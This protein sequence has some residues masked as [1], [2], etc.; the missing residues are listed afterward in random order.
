MPCAR[1]CKWGNSLGVRIPRDIARSLG[2]QAGDMLEIFPEKEGIS[3]RKGSGGKA[4][5]LEDIIEC[6]TCSETHPEVSWGDP[7][8]EETW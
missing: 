1:V 4:Y 8:G 6:F 7:K 3:L 2:L 5:R